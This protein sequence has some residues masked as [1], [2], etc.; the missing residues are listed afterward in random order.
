MK[1]DEE[2]VFAVVV[3]FVACFCVGKYKEEKECNLC[4]A[5]SVEEV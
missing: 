3:K 5:S 1:Y 2:V 4:A